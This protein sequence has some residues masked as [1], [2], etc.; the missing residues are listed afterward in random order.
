M[1]HS[2]VTQ[3][4]RIAARAISPS[5]LRPDGL[6]T[7][8]RSYGTYEVRDSRATRR[9]L[10]GNHPVRMQELERE[11]GTCRLLY[12]FRRREDAAAMAAALNHGETMP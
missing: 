2:A 7:A 9:F 8:P 1:K 3:I 4:R 12:L 11:F 6:L 5:S 10:F